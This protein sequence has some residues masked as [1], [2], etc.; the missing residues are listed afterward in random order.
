[1]LDYVLSFYFIASMAGKRH[2]FTGSDYLRN[3]DLGDNQCFANNHLCQY[4]PIDYR[5]LG[6][7]VW[8]KACFY[9]FIFFCF[10]QK[11]NKKCTYAKNIT[12]VFLSIL[13]E[14][15]IQYFKHN[16]MYILDHPEFLPSLINYCLILISYYSC[17]P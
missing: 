5:N 4:L 9:H 13:V 12:T 7:K 16:I 6:K 8:I 10:W 2:Q 11:K 3:F 14:N 15:L 17:A 1:M